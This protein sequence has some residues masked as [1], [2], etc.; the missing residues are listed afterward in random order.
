ME[1]R[2]CAVSMAGFG[3]HIVVRR[4]QAWRT[5]GTKSSSERLAFSQVA[6]QMLCN[7]WQCEILQNP[8]GASDK[9]L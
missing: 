4:P 1:K 2:I 9:A 5:N 6:S 3:V 7:A 8:V